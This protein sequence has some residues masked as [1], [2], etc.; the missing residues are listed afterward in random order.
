MT[1]FATT[2]SVEAL[3]PHFSGD[4]IDRDHPSYDAA[5][6]V[7]NGEIQRH[8]GLIAR[9]RGAAD[10]AAAIRFA[11]EHDLPASVRGGGHAVAGYA[12]LD[13]GIVIDLSAMTGTR[14]DPVAR[15]IQAEGGCLQSDVDREAQAFGLAATGGFVSHTGV[16]GLTLGGGIGHLMRKLGLSIDALRECDVV[17]A[18]GE[19]VTA[20]AEENADLF[21]GLRGGGGNFGVVTNFTFDLQ[22]LGPTVL[23][24]LIAW[25]AAQAPTV[26]AFV[27]DFIA[28]AP[29]DLGL[30]ANLRLAPP[31]P[32]F[33]TE[34][35]GTPIV[36]LV[37]TWAG[38]VAAGEKYL[39]PLRAL[40]TPLVDAIAPKPYVA[41][42]KMLDPAVP[43][44]RHYYWKSHRLGPLTDDVIAV[45]CHHLATISSPLSSVPIFSFGGAMARVP[46]DATAFPQRDAAHDINIVGSWLPEQAGEADRH[47][48]WVRGFFDELAPHSRGVYVNFT[49][50]DAQSRVGEAYNDA[51]RER[52]GRLKAAYD[53]TNF[54]SRNAN[55]EPA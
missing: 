34:V 15:T 52:L 55:I 44:G 1:T 49:S 46:E 53:P 43:H 18:D 40:G 32:V 16:A 22:P 37:V 29:D 25:P 7:W 33:P 45:I 28:D 19:F 36:G 47:R 10:V 39:K 50:D 2:P 30:M 5:R 48:A 3:A 14:V 4:L 41:H 54:F 38:D 26:L 35:H 21:W 27:R 8:P 6:Q 9:C 24:G 51:Q 17:T 20:N 13:D 11:R 23:A 42:Q 12:V 31:L